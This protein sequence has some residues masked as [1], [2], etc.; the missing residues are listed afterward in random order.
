ME[1][2]LGY[3]YGAGIN[4]LTGEYD[5]GLIH[6]LR[7][8]PTVGGD[9]VLDVYMLSPQ[10]FSDDAAI[11]SASVRDTVIGGGRSKHTFKALE[12]LREATHNDHYEMKI[13]KSKTCEP[14]LWFCPDRPVVQRMMD[15]ASGTLTMKVEEYAIVLCLIPPEGSQWSPSEF[16]LP[17]VSLFPRT[18]AALLELYDALVLDNEENPAE[19]GVGYV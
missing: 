6:Q 11:L 3:A 2:E 8:V 17:A 16:R 7:V 12:R 9:I 14:L 4:H 15:E 5:I 1:L 19:N 10:G 13:G 18:Y